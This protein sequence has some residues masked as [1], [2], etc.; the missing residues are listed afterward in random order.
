MSPGSAQALSSRRQ[1]W[2]PQAKTW[3]LISVIF[4]AVSVW[5]F[6]QG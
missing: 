1:G 6:S 3:L 4:A 2:H 5:L